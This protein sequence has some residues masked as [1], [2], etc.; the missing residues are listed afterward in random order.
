MKGWVSLVIY[1][2]KNYWTFT[3]YLVL[4][5]LLEIIVVKTC[6]LISG[7]LFNFS[8]PFHNVGSLPLNRTYRSDVYFLG[9]HLLWWGSLFKNLGKIFLTFFSC[10]FLGLSGSLHCPHC[11]YCMH[12]HVFQFWIG[13]LRPSVCTYGRYG[14]KSLLLCSVGGTFHSFYQLS[15]M[16]VRR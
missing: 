11:I 3:M 16:D 2:I 1:S 7:K 6:S 8:Q 5:P 10:S 12:Q 9:D 14:W 13:G 4:L 15:F